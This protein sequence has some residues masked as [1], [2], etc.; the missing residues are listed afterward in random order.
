MVKPIWP[1]IMI[2]IMS[3]RTSCRKNRYT[4]A[5]NSILKYRLFGNNDENA[6]EK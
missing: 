1:K 2:K 5:Q 6:V 3:D 4:S